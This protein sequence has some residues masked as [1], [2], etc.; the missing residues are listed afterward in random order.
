[1]NSSVASE[2]SPPDFTFINWPRMR[3][4]EEY[5]RNGII[6]NNQEPIDARTIELKPI[7]ASACATFYCYELCFVIMAIDCGTSQYN[8][9]YARGPGNSRWP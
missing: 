1:M 4:D 6:G 9:P 5:G 2:Q 3:K 8:R 7:A